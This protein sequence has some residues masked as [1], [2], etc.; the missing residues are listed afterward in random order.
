[1]VRIVQEILLAKVDVE[2]L[3]RKGKIRSDD[4]KFIIR[5]VESKEG[6]DA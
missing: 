1:M 2:R 5:I 3:L 6:K 4:K